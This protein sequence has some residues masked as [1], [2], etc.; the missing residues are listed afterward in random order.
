MAGTALNSAFG[1]G[2]VRQVLEVVAIL[3]AV[4]ACQPD[5]P[6]GTFPVGDV[7]LA[8]GSG[9]GGGG[10][11]VAPTITATDPASAVRDTTIDVTIFGSGFTTGAKATWSLA[12]DTGF[13][14]VKSTKVVASDRLI[15]RIEVPA[16]AP[17]AV[18]DVEVTLSNGKKG[19]GAE[20]FEVQLGD[21][22]A[23]FWFPTD[24][25]SLGLRSD[26]LFMNG[27][28]SVYA[29]GVCGVNSK[30]FATGAASGSGD[31]IM[32]TNNPQSK[33]RKCS[34]YPRTVTLEYGPG[35]VE[36]APVFINVREIANTTFQIP[37]GTTAQRILRV[38]VGGR[39]EGLAWAD[40][41]ANGTNTNGGDRVNVT[42]V[43]ASTWL[44]QSQPYPDN[45]AYCITTGQLYH[46][47]VQ[48]L[49]VTDRPMP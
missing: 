36:A 45:Q 44:V 25:A 42:R 12:G 47:N 19:V 26:H 30:L 4:A 21:P 9:G 48:F 37:V 38:N 6:T 41:L 2:R 7:G 35:D 23:A 10:G 27:T 13:V 1:R 34:S 14:H 32:H 8:K 17:I 39:C 22:T 29:N 3:M 46:L 40:Q 28:S 11:S 18:Y 24:D 31:A 16:T 20:M 49:V 33:D 15:A 5:S 43:D